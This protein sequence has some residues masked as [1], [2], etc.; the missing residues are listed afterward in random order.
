M[1]KR[2]VGLFVAVAMLV[3][4]LPMM[5]AVASSIGVSKY[6][7][8]N[9]NDDYFDAVN[10]LSELNIIS[11]Y[12]DGSFKPDKKVTRA[13]MATLIISALNET[14]M[15]E[16]SKGYIKFDDVSAHWA[17]GYVNQGVADGFI[18]GMSDSMFAPDASVTYMQAMKMLV[19]AIGY[20]TYSQRDG[21]WPNGYKKWG[22]NF[23][24]GN[25]VYES[26]S[27]ALDRGE[28]AI[29]LYNT[30][31]APVCV[32]KEFEKTIDGQ[33]IPVLATKDGTGRDFRN[34]LIHCNDVYLVEGYMSSAEDFVITSSRNFD[35]EY[36]AE[37]SNYKISL[38]DS[39]YDTIVSG[40]CTAYILANDYHDYSLT[41][42]LSGNSDTKSY[43][44]SGIGSIDFDDDSEVVEV[45]VSFTDGRKTG[46]VKLNEIDKSDLIYTTTGIKGSAV[47]ITSPERF[48]NAKAVISFEYNPKGL[49]ETN[50]SDLAIGWYNTDLDRIEILPD[51]K[52]NT[53]SNTV[54]VETKH[55][56]E[57]ILVDSKE[58][59][60]VWQ[61]GQTVVREVDSNGKFTKKF[62]VQLVVDCS[63]SMDG[64]RI[65]RARECTYAFIEKLSE[66]DR[67]SVI[68][69]GNS[70]DTVIEPTIVK[71]ANMDRVENKVM[72]MS[73]GSGTN[74]NAAFSK[75]LEY[76][77]FSDTEYKNIIVFLSDGESSENVPNTTLNK[78]ANH[79]VKIVS[80]AL[81]SDSSTE[82]MKRLSDATDG[83]YVYARDSS[84]L[85]MVY[86]AI[87]GSL[88]GVDA[89]DTDGDGLPD[90]V[91][92]TGMKNQ[93]G[94]I[95]R[96]DPNLYDT[97]GDGI[98]DG[99]EMGKL[100]ET[101]K[102]TEEDKKNGITSCVYFLMVSD[103][104]EGHTV[105]G[106]VE[107]GDGL[108][109]S[110]TPTVYKSEMKANIVVKITNTSASTA[111]DLLIYFE[112]SDCLNH[113]LVVT[114]TSGK[115]I[116]HAGWED[117]AYTISYS[118]ILVPKD[119]FDVVIPLTCEN[120]QDCSDLHYIKVWATSNKGQSQ[121]R[122]VNLDF[123]Y[124]DSEQQD[125]ITDLD[126]AIMDF[127]NAVNDCIDAIR[128]L[129]SAQ[130][131]G[132][133]Q[134][135]KTDAMNVVRQIP[136]Q[137]GRFVE[138]NSM[139]TAEKDAIKACF[140][141]AMFDYYMAYAVKENK[142]YFDDITPSDFA[143]G[144]LGLESK[145]IRSTE[146]YINDILKN[147]IINNQYT[148]NGLTY[149][150]K[151]TVPSAGA[152]MV[153]SAEFKNISTG[154]TYYYTDTI[155]NDSGY[156]SAKIAMQNYVEE[157][158]E[159]YAKAQ[160]GV[161]KAALKDLQDVFGEIN[162]RQKIIKKVSFT[163]KIKSTIDKLGLGKFDEFI[164]E[165]ISIHNLASDWGD[166]ATYEQG[167][168]VEKV[169]KQ[170]QKTYNN[171][172]K[173]FDGLLDGKKSE[174]GSVMAVNALLSEVKKKLEFLLSAGKEYMTKAK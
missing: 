112:T 160:I 93:Y 78:L 129:D 48:G 134:E 87:Q 40:Q 15:A 74:F 14:E 50:P 155:G 135:L 24:I 150:V 122:T 151:V 127:N 45:N 59:Y 156:T 92:T 61:R 3:A 102:L 167:S 72:S 152:R 73:D 68:K 174:R 154:H 83:Q 98:S 99:V 157:L 101:D 44:N 63:G 126:S 26:D 22:N 148:E 10:L 28:V 31:N 23:G 27:A 60:S 86:N 62:N 34:V 43:L 65:S 138:Y 19:S 145:V 47:E 33:T 120:G 89:T 90:A 80:V 143:D 84:D 163:N 162:F 70:A 106:Y 30:V 119:S 77:D 37:G 137:L 158:C 114:D 109:L 7:D 66:S 100:I 139:S 81:G 91:E 16:A 12:P 82:S 111:R 49:G 124:T 88:I 96:T 144:G 170:A 39:N 153:I 67:F 64:D 5:P 164:G 18:A 25:G 128:E 17:I 110:I 35:D 29:M 69:F 21:G 123:K 13:E 147:N 55:F 32:I 132:E 104:V 141:D 108:E 53:S 107:K 168:D 116:E 52:V 133:E 125:G 131:A 169:M 75:C 105:K 117:D 54:S 46:N 57:Y 1:R 115:I 41:Y 71:R 113:S 4:M 85:D 36:Y 140:Y 20:E 38:S 79:D 161:T 8:V 142:K 166:L 76:L 130:I 173:Y 172:D 159:L 94:A 171:M 9:K 146:K 51:C 121:V 2:I 42:I 136:F 56:S 11:G 97:D 6:W 165:C 103:P 149:T 58:W 95:I 118:D